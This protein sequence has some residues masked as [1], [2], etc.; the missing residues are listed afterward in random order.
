MKTTLTIDHRELSNQH[1]KTLEKQNDHFNLVY[2]ALPLGDYV[3]EEK[4]IIERKTLSDFLAS[5]KDGRLFNQAYRLAE[6]EIPAVLILEGE[7]RDVADSNM[8]RNALLGTFVHLSG[9]LGI[10]ILRSKNYNETIFLIQSLAKQIDK[11]NERIKKRVKR[12]QF[13]PYKGNQKAKLDVL[14]AIPGLGLD[15]AISLMDKFGSV[16]SISNVDKKELIKVKG[17]G[18]KTAENILNVLG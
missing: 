5:V 16:K 10:P 11:L 18:K 3:L 8:K 15:K 13:N 9:I 7:K 1:K 6:N 12:T 4:I 17:I 2:K 14:L